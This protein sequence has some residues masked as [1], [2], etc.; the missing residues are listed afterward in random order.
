MRAFVATTRKHLIVG[1]VADDDHAIWS[2][3][4]RMLILEF[5]FEA[6]VPIARTYGQAL[7]RVALADE[8]VGRAEA[9]WSRLVDLSIK[10]GTVAVK[11]IE[12]ASGPISPRQVS[13]LP[14]TAIMGRHAP[15]SPN[16]RRIR[17][18]TS[19]RAWRV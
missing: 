1:G 17:L 4:R 5:D 19:G 3:L 15:G 2:L 16:S 14:A 7:A 6:T 9:L 13:G 18:P 12:M 10:T 11:S 8:D